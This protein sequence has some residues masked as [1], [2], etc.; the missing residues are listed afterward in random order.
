[1]KDEGWSPQFFSG[2]ILEAQRQL[3][4]LSPTEAE[5]DFLVATLQPAGGAHILDV[6]CGN[7]RLSLALAARGY[8]I[9]GVD[10]AGPLLEDGRRAAAERGLEVSFEQRDMRDLPWPAAF[11]HAFCFGNSF[12]YFDDDGNAAFLRAVHDALRPGGTFALET[13]LVGESLFTQL[14][15]RRW[16]PFDDLFFLHET[17]YDPPSGRLTSGYTLIR[18]GEVVERKQAVYRVYT[19][20]ELLGVLAGAGFADVQCFGSLQR[21]PYRLG[22]PGLW[23]LARRPLR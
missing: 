2:L 23:L 9:K 21:E 16:Y 11:D 5:A 15:Q 20:R 22:S 14:T 18:G 7:G 12:A 3:A 17:S 10:L 1:M 8:R 13:H 19:C 6:P 4:A